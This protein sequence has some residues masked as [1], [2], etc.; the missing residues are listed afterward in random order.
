MSS[1]SR[2]AVKDFK[3]RTCDAFCRPSS[4]LSARRLQTHLD[5]R[6]VLSVSENGRSCAIQS[7]PWSPIVCNPNQGL[8]FLPNIVFGFQVL[9]YS[10]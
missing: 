2:F 4:S 5:L 1:M 9:L 10:V 8:F 7:K 6:G 3:L